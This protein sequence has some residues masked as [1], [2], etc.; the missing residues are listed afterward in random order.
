MT[1]TA[2]RPASVPAR[3]A[4]AVRRARTSQDP[5]ADGHHV[6]SDPRTGHEVELPAGSRLQVVFAR[7]GLGL[8]QWRVED[9][10]GHLVPLSEAGHDFCFLVFGGHGD[11]PRPLRLVRYRADSDET[12]EVRD[13]MVRAAG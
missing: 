1:V 8:S 7:K 3:R 6:V 10:P 5:R 4:R 12:R 9:V 13:I 2:V 11:Q